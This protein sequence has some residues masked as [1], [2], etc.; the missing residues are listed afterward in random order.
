[1]LKVYPKYHD[2]NLSYITM[3]RCYWKTVKLLSFLLTVNI[4]TKKWHYAIK[5]ILKFKQI[6]YETTQLLSR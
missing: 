2:N 6:T 3:K 5:I 1:M 4:G